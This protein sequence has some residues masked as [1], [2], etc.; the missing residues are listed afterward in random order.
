M[1]A[2]LDIARRSSVCPHDCPSVCALDV[3]VIGGNRIG[4]VHGAPDHP[5][6]QGVVCAKVA[7]YSER[8]HHPDRLTRPLRRVGPKGSGQF[9]AVGWDEALDIVADKFLSAE[10]AYGG[11]SVWPY[12][13]AG[14][15][16]LVMRDGL[17]RLT[18]VKRY[19]RYHST[20]CTGV[21][22]PGYIA[23]TG[24][25]SG[26][27]SLEIAKSD[28][29]V[30]WGTNAVATQVNLMTHAIRARKELGAKIVVI[31][32]YDNETMRQADLALRLRPGTDGALAC[33]VMHVLFR[34]GFADR[35][36]LGRMTDAPH[37]L[38]AHLATRT[39]EWAAAITGLDAAQIEEFAALIG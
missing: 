35:D 14:T 33:A 22:F 37:E 6:T 7:R 17:E 5:Y 38:E 39:P 25:M 16:G 29:V 2:P 4:R 30:I 1:N 21:S 20:I 36:Y 26:V 13:Y 15:M 18:H 28:C 27:S 9:V 8:I 11:E 24:R 10:R 19:S 23:G 32:I 34:D 12:W 31:D 3:E